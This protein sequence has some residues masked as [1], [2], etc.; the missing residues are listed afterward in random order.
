MKS[1]AAFISGLIF[2]LGLGLSGMTRPS[3]VLAFLDVSGAWDPSLGFVMVGAVAVFGICHVFIRRRS[4]PVLDNKFFVPEMKPIDRKL[5]VGALIFGIG[6]GLAGYCPGPALVGI[7][8][9]A[10]SVLAF[11][12]ALIVGMI[13]HTLAAPRLRK[14]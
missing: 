7:A 2:A 5:L 10:W 14:L 3:K 4:A 8:T 13:A 9:G 11:V 6:W 12:A 1:V